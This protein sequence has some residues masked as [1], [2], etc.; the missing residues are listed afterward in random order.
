MKQPEPADGDANAKRSG[1]RN[2]QL[3]GELAV[4]HLDFLSQSLDLNGHE[5]NP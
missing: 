4:L 2:N 3:H 1:N 5:V